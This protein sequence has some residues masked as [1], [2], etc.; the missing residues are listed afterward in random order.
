ME[1]DTTTLPNTVTI[2]GFKEF[3]DKMDKF[4]KILPGE[5]DAAAEIAA[6]TWARNADRD[7]PKDQGKLHGNIKPIKATEGVWEVVSPSLY[8]PFME[9]GTKSRVS[10][11]AELQG[12]ASQFRGKGP[13]GGA[14]AIYEWARRVGI[15]QNQWIF[16][17]LSIIR[18][19]VH[20]HP[21]F[22]KQRPIVEKQ[23]IGDL[24]Q[25]LETLD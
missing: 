11:P 19:G 18:K 20:P 14:K 8:S 22:F 25:I 13:P 4:S 7:A 12:Y 21:F 5:L 17:Y 3:S 9:W 15:P 6:Q 16:V 23:L 24:Q 10:V 1:G 2:R